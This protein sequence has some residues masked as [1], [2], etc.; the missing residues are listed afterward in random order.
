MNNQIQI[1]NSCGSKKF[2]KGRLDGYAKV[3][4]L[5]KTFS[6]GSGIILTFCKNCGEVFSMKVENLNKF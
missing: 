2:T 5:N 4:P 1:C 3:R 6:L